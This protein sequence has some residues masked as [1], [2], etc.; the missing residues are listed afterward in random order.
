M[1]NHEPVLE[2][3]E[4]V[5][6]AM[7]LVL[8]IINAEGLQLADVGT[9]HPDQADRIDARLKEAGAVDRGGRLLRV[10]RSAHVASGAFQLVAE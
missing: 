5:E 3:D 10:G 6:R 4:G 8:E 7:A 2:H 9:L 1:T